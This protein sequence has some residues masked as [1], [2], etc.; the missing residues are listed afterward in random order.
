VKGLRIDDVENL[1]FAIERVLVPRE[2][3]AL[4]NVHVKLK[5]AGAMTGIIFFTDPAHDSNPSAGDAGQFR[6]IGRLKLEVR[7]S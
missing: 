2:Q 7:T 6:P 1:W 5:A 4:L 3:A